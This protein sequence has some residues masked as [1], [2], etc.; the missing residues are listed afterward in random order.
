MLIV[1][2]TVGL[3]KTCCIRGPDQI[4]NSNGGCM[5]WTCDVGRGVLSN[6]LNKATE[7]LTWREL[8]MP[9]SVRWALSRYGKMHTSYH[10]EIAPW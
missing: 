4:A 3:W 2:K 7:M 1:Y 5:S 9:T 10:S 8:K 6:I